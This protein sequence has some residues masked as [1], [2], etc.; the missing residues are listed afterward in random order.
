MIV[1]GGGP[2]APRFYD[3]IKSSGLPVV[4]CSTML[5]PLQRAGIKVD[6]CCIR[7]PGGVMV[8]HFKGAV[9]DGLLVYHQGIYEMILPMWNGERRCVTDIPGSSVLH[10]AADT[11]VKMG[12]DTVH[13]VGAD[14]CFSNGKSHAEGVV[15]AYEVREW[16]DVEGYRTDW[17]LVTYRDE[18]RRYMAEHP[19]V[20]W[21]RHG[22]GLALSGVVMD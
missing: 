11:A 15:T 14:F 2:S 8:F 16:I 1:V 19:G 17:S 20:R 22:D 12:A 13:L 5:L 10:M 18:M 7:D 6:V 21:M 4:A 9:T 3:W